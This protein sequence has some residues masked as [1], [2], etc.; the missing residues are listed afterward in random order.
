[1]EDWQEGREPCLETLIQGSE[2]K[3]SQ[4][5]ALFLDW[6]SKHQLRPV[7]ANYLARTSRGR[8]DLRFS[9]SGDGDTERFFRTHYVPA[10][11]PEHKLE[12]LQRK[13]NERL[14]LVVFEIIRDSRCSEC[15]QEMPADS[16]LFVEAN[17]PLC[18]SCAG[19]D[20]LVYLSRGDATLTR[21]SRKYSVLSAVV[22][23]FSRARKRYERQGCLVEEA[24][25]LKAEEECVADA[26]RRAWL[27]EREAIRRVDAD[28]T[29]TGQMAGKIL[30]LFPRCP[31]EEAL[32]IA[33]HTT[34]RGSG[35]T[36]RSAA[37]RKLEAQSVELAVGAAVRHCHTNYGELLAESGNR[38]WARGQVRD[39]INEILRFLR[40]T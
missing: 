35:R 27:R 10:N 22:V 23:R 19:L 11:L 13:L 28:V 40:S 31:P 34:L 36:G 20:H 15:G 18:L 33:E 25:L 21:R 1:M 7:E 38:A 8:W 17:Q 16:L 30:E 9:A 2:T 26:S 14:E 4:T 3:I 24:A 5:K 6:V 32:A 39:Q 37:G 29:F 12:K